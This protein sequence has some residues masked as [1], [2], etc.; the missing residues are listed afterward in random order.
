MKKHTA[1]Y[2]IGGV[3]VATA[4]YYFNKNK[5]YSDAELNERIKETVKKANFYTKKYAQEKGKKTDNQVYNSIKE[6]F[7]NAKINGKDLSRATVDKV[8]NLILI[9]SLNQEGD[10]SLGV[11]S[12]EDFV[13]LTEYIKNPKNIEKQYKQPV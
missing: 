9:T 5:Q 13:F 3:L 11:A 12:K 7:N 1:Y 6:I 2:I 4:I 10:S 8:L